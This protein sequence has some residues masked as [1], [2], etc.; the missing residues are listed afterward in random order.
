MNMIDRVKI[1]NTTIALI[2]KYIKT[3]SPAKS[4]LKIIATEGIKFK[5]IKSSKNFLGALIKGTTNTPYIFINNTI[6]NE[7]RKNFTIAHEF[8]HFILQHHLQTAIFYCKESDIKEEGEAISEQEREANYF[9]SYFLLP[10]DKVIKKFTQLFRWHVGLSGRIFLNVFPHNKSYSN[11]KIISSKLA[12]EFKVSVTA[13]KI[14]LTD[15]GLVKC[16]FE[17]MKQKEKGKWN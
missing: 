2:S 10:K 1:E 17:D 13:L 7:G 5:E 9:A 14:R 8:G 15:L 11:W 12:K 4:L 6:D 3:G 16:N